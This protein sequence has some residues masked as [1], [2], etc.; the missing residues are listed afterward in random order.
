MVSGA[1]R[2]A[3]TA[4]VYHSVHCRAH[5]NADTAP[6]RERHKQHCRECPQAATVSTYL[7]LRRSQHSLRHAAILAEY[8]RHLAP[9]SLC[10]HQ[11]QQ[12][13][14]ACADW[15]LP[16]APTLQR[17]DV[18]WHTCKS[19][20]AVEDEP[21]ILLHCPGCVDLKSAHSQLFAQPQQSLLRYSSN[22]QATSPPLSEQHCSSMLI[23]WAALGVHLGQIRK[24]HFM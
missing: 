15:T 11:M 20:S 22:L 9:Q 8:Q 13:S 7:R 3:T 18:T 23:S 19:T 24:R 1:L 10:Q 6:S 14:A 5:G 2:S 4:Q 12:S 17:K 16:R 21:H